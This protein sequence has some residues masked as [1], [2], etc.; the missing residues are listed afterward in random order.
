MDPDHTRVKHE[1]IPGSVRVIA[2]VVVA[3]GLAVYLP[4]VC[5]SLYWFDSAEFVNT[6]LLLDVPHPPGYPLYNL[7]AALA[8]RVGLG[9]VPERVNALSAIFSA[10]SLGA[11][12]LLVWA[13]TRRTLSALLG[14]VL[15]GSAPRFVEM[16]LVAEVYPLEILLYMVCF[17]LLTRRVGGGALYLA[18]GLLVFH[19]PTNL[20]FAL[21][22]IHLTGWKHLRTRAAAWLLVGALPYLHTF[23]V[24]FLRPV[25][26]HGLWS[27]NYFDYPRDLPTFFRVCTGTLY[28]SNLRWAGMGREVEEIL[29]MVSFLE[30]QVGL[31]P[32]I[33]GLAGLL[34][35][36]APMELRMAFL[37]NAAFFLHYDVLEKDTMYFP[38][39]VAVLVL[40]LVALTRLVENPRLHPAL[41]TVILVASLGLAAHR[42]TGTF[43]RMQRTDLRAVER[44][45]EG[46]AVQLPPRTFFM[47]TDDQLLHPMVHLIMIEKRRPDLALHIIEKWSPEVVQVLTGVLAK[48]QTAMS[49]LFMSREDMDRVRR[50]FAAIPEGPYYRLEKLAS[51]LP[52]LTGGAVYPTLWGESLRTQVAASH[53]PL[54]AGDHIRVRVTMQPAGRRVLVFRL[55][56]ALGRTPIH[57]VFPCGYQGRPSAPDGSLTED[58]LLTLPAGLEDW[59]GEHAGARLEI[60]LLP[61]MEVAA[62]RGYV[63]IEPAPEAESEIFKGRA[64]ASIEALEQGLPFHEPVYRYRRG[65]LAYSELA[66]LELRVRPPPAAAPSAPR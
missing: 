43:E 4:H 62:D 13:H 21:G 27:I 52:P 31:L 17:L 1:P 5:P 24:F 2:A 7:I 58:Y 29:A 14:V 11:L 10:A 30:A 38:S 49:P 45:L 8:V 66:E 64:G 23:W 57:W 48:G 56:A 36:R 34:H 25:P 19:R 46:A 44:C 32:A 28:A 60:G 37:A 3:A 6:A 55:G 40:F 26:E 12:F 9:E 47:V 61:G 51:P 22:A 41:G 50:E 65:E 16:S 33:L 18:L 63:S 42:G 59:A 39:L 35:R 54:R 53:R 20:F 15:L